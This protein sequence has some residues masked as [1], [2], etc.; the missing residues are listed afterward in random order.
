MPRTHAPRVVAQLCVSTLSFNR[1]K[2]VTNSL[3]R[4]F[5][6]AISVCASFTSGAAPG[7]LDASFGNGGKV[8]TAIGQR[9]DLIAASALQAD[10]KIVVTGEC[11]NGNGDAVNICLAR[12]LPNGALD[13]S[14]R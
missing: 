1:K 3:L 7:D 12:Y 4:L 11:A 5:F 8:I 13:T 2:F 9:N 6:I 10:G 14:L